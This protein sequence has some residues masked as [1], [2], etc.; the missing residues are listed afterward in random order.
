MTTDAPL[1]MRLLSEMNAVPDSR[2]SATF[3]TAFSGDCILAIE[4]ERGWDI[5]GG[6]LEAGESPAEALDRELIEEAGAS[7][8]WKSPFAV[9]CSAQSRQV[10][11]VYVGGG[12]A[13]GDFVK[14]KDVL[15][16]AMLTI[17]ELVSRYYGDRN[18]M[19]QLIDAGRKRQSFY[20]KQS[21]VKVL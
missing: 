18:F 20:S 6:Y 1:T 19:R 14:Q 13:F 3:I 7:V 2:V 8:Q 17:D 12:I 10:M 9:L 16:R 15:G 5:P 11:L 4:N 21:D